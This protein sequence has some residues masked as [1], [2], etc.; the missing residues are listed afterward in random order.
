MQDLAKAYKEMKDEA[1]IAGTE[2]SSND[3]A[4]PSGLAFGIV[5][6]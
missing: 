2:A 3:P 6:C 4:M 1:P 5:Q